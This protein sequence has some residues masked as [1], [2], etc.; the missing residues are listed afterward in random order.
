[1]ALVIS[2]P[3]ASA[4]GTPNGNCEFTAPNSAA[5]PAL[6]FKNARRLTPRR[7]LRPWLTLVSFIVI[8][9]FASPDRLFA[10]RRRTRQK[11]AA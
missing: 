5:V 7:P 9:S 10:R 1:M 8:P 11:A 2:G 3:S 4:I 6:D